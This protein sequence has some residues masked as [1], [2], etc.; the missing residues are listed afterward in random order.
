MAIILPITTNTGTD[1]PNAFMTS[2]VEIGYEGALISLRFWANYQA[3]KTKKEML[4]NNQPKKFFIPKETKVFR[5]NFTTAKLIPAGKAPVINLYDNILK[6]ING[7]EESIT[8]YTGETTTTQR[9]V[10]VDGEQTVQ[11]ITSTIIDIKLDALLGFDFTNYKDSFTQ[12]EFDLV[13]N[14]LSN[15]TDAKI[16]FI[17]D[18]EQ[19]KI[20]S[21]SESSWFNQ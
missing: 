16:I 6:G 19:Y 15:P 3:Y 1:Y 4:F 7:S 21:A 20:W 5:D 18:T 12:E 17:E 2:T 14:G 11:E 13:I 10:I 9:I 8:F